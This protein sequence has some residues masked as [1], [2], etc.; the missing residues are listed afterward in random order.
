MEILEPFLLL[1]VL[2][3]NLANNRTYTI[4]IICQ[5]DTT[6]SLD[7]NESNSFYTI[8]GGYISKS[9]SQHDVGTPIISPYIFGGPILILNINFLI[10]IITILT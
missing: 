4:D 5:C 7:K 1:L 6:D 10:P 3:F 2:C 9:N 8:R